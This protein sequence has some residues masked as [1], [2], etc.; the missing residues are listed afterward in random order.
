[1]KAETYAYMRRNYGK[2][3]ALAPCSSSTASLLYRAAFVPRN[4]SEYLI[5]N[6]FC[7]VIVGQK[8]TERK[9]VREIKPY[10]SFFI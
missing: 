2:R 9:P 5:Q 7:R 10:E 4:T 1:M 3:V 8:G 6:P